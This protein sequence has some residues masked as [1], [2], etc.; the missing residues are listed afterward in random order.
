LD[1]EGHDY[2]TLESVLKRVLEEA[3]SEARKLGVEF[4]FERLKE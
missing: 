3:Q 1:L 4:G 2:K